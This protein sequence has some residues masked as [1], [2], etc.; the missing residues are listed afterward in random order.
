MASFTAMYLDGNVD[1]VDVY[2]ANEHVAP[3]VKKMATPYIDISHL[4]AKYLAGYQRPS[5]ETG[6]ETIWEQMKDKLLNVYYCPL[7]APSLAGLPMAYVFTAEHDPL[8]DEGLLYLYRLKEAGVKVEHAHSDI[9]IHGIA[10]F[11]KDLPEAEKI[12]TGITR[13]ITENL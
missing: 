6:N 11:V 1:K 3:K 9:G 5:V 2:L 8:R 10:S 12:F 7:V 13:F 4:P